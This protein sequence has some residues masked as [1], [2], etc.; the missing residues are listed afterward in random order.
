MFSDPQSITVAAAPVSL[1]RVS[2][3]N[4]TSTYRTADG[5]YELQ[6]AHS[7][8]KRERTV[9]KLTA[10]KV[11]VD[12]FDAS[13]SRSYTAPI[14]VVIDS[15]LNGAGFTDTELKDQLIALADLIKSANFATK[16][17]GKES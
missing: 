7:A 17:L 2:V 12:P 11:G 8:N 1:P 15:P 6:I 3:G 16:I 10:N 5:S 4:L 14:Y 13:R 9:V